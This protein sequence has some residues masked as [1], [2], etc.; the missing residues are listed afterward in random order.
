MPLVDWLTL[1]GVIKLKNFIF[2]NKIPDLH[3][4]HTK[5]LHLIRTLNPYIHNS[6]F[7]H[8]TQNTVEI[9]DV[10]GLERCPILKFLKV[11]T[12]H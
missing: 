1:N 11:I 10:F 6:L 12:N 4:T 7:S 5:M 2:A 9:I 3:I 8:K